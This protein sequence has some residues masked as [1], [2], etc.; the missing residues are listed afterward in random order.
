MENY[1][2]LLNPY[3]N[4]APVVINLAFDLHL[5]ITCNDGITQNG[6]IERIFFTEKGTE[7]VFR[8]TRKIVLSIP[9]DLNPNYA[10]LIAERSRY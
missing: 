1:P 6:R 8:G 10:G 5:C 7:I 4:A 3:R 2:R 9:I